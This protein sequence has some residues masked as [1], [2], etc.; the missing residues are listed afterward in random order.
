MP[1][2]LIRYMKGC[3][4]PQWFFFRSNLENYITK[5]GLAWIAVALSSASRRLKKPCNFTILKIKP[6]VKTEHGAQVTQTINL[7]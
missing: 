3:E 1:L 5:R 2:I 7:R 6:Q 4:I